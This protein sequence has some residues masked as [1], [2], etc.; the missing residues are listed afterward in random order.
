[1]K[2]SEISV[3]I[4]T[5]LLLKGIKLPLIESTYYTVLQQKYFVLP[6][7]SSNWKYSLLKNIKILISFRMNIRYIVQLL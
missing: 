6:Y 2:R 5:L 1:M 4:L 3:N 7:H